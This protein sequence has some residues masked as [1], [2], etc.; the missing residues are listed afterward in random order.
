MSENFSPSPSHRERTEPDALS[1]YASRMI[2][3]TVIELLSQMISFD[4]VNEY[5]SLRVFPEKA[6]LESLENI[7]QKWGLS[8]ERLKISSSPADEAFNLLITHVAN[9]NAPWL[10]FESHADTVSVEGMTI[11]PFN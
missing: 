9:K 5:V 7:A 10:L 11:D 6:L 4:T 3:E 8:T 1:G 2:P